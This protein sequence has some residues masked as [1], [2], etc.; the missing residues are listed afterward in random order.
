MNTSFLTKTS[1]FTA[2]LTLASLSLGVNPSMAQW[3]YT[4]DSFTDGHNAQSRVGSQSEFEFYGMA[5]MDDGENIFI[6]I[7]SNLSLDG[8]TSS[9]AQSGV[10]SYGDFFFNFTGSGLDDA[11]G[12]LFAINFANNTDSGVSEAGVYRNV[13]GTNVAGINSGFDHLNHHANTVNN[14]AVNKT[15]GGEGARIGDLASNDAYWQSGV[16]QKYKVVNSIA[17]GE[18]VG[19][20][21]MLEASTLAALG[22]DFGQFSATGTYTFGFSF[23]R[24][25]LPSGDFIAHIFA[26]CINDGMAMVGNLADRSI[27]DPQPVP[28]PASVL[29]L[30]AVGGLMLKGKRNRT[31]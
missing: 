24:N 22:L 19:G 30:L 23:D 11:N 26:E 18:R 4:I 28:E 20:I 8:A 31:A 6:A 9:H 2:G 14:L 3:N 21:N 5:L 13:T 7:N 12:N 17:S 10:I 16:N 29:G 15:G 25:L 1:L 27:V